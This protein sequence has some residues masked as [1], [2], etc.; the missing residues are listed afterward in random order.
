MAL[1]ALGLG[2]VFTARDLASPAMTRLGGRFGALD[3]V[4]TRFGQRFG[5]GMR[6]LRTAGLVFAA[7]G[8]LGTV[9]AFGLARA[10]GRFEEGLARVGGVT[11]ATVPE[12][13]ALRD[14]AIEVGIATTF[15]PDEAVEG[16]TSLAT[17]GF[18][19]SEAMRL[20]GP[21]SALAEGG[22]IGLEDAARAV[23]SATRVFSLSMDEAQGSADRLLRITQLTALQAGDLSLALGTVARGAGAT[24]QNLNEMLIAM[25]LVRNTGVEV[26]VAASGVSSAL[27]FMARQ[28]GEI[29][30]SLGVAITDVDGNFRDFLDIVLES[31]VALD[32]EFP[33]AADRASEALRLF[34]RF[35]SSAFGAVSRQLTQGIRGLNGELLT[36]ADAV[37][38]LRDQMQNATG[39]ADE[40]RERILA[41]FPGQLALL[42]GSVRTLA[43]V[44]G[45]NF[46]NA[47]KPIVRGVI[48]FV[49]DLITRWNAI[50]SAIRDGISSFLVG[51]TAMLTL[52][53]TFVAVS[54]GLALIAPL[55]KG[56]AIALG[57]LLLA[58]APLVLI[59]GAAVL[60]VQA[61]RFAMDFNLG[62]IATFVRGIVSRITLAWNALTEL[63]TRG[64]FTRAI[65]DELRRSE[66]QGLRRFV[67]GV[68]GIAFRLQRFWDGLMA[69]IRGGM[70]TLGPAIAAMIEAFRELADLFG[71]GAAKGED[72]ADALPTSAFVRFGQTLGRVLVRVARFFVEGLTT[73]LIFA[74]GVIKT[75]RSIGAR[76]SAFFAPLRPIL[77][78]IGLQIGMV[79][80]ALGQLS[81]QVQK[82]GSTWTEFVT[83]V[84]LLAVL[85]LPI[86]R[87]SLTG[88]LIMVVLL[89]QQFTALIGVF[90]RALDLARSI[91]QVLPSG[92]RE[93]G[94][95]AFGAA[96]RA[97]FGGGGAAGLAKEPVAAGV[98]RGGVGEALARPV[99]ESA[100]ARAARDESN[101]RVQQ[102][103]ID[104]LRA[105]Q[106]GIF[107][108]DMNLDGR[109]LQEFQGRME[110]TESAARGTPVEGDQ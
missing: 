67:L 88:I 80:S 83:V 90:T 26:S 42:S 40:F 29:Q 46:A 34:G 7:T 12:L 17:M 53:G 109:R 73:F 98:A 85:L 14:R 57:G 82:G 1:N 71:F 38:F 107:R 11:R 15:S 64:G 66:N 110:R 62:G 104:A 58:L 25:G 55:L 61:F 10:A 105:Q 78:E 60:G 108:I 31:S 6:R 95:A 49:N 70:I 79:F 5:A 28:A 72:M 101:V 44:L 3:R 23:A 21:A 65:S 43:I 2:F 18:Q 99:R 48:A 39:V 37:E 33:N 68:F 9:A 52:F 76:L 54:A 93:F 56:I 30:S 102:D 69:G 8:A 91:A 75:S 41:T 74:Q 59:F 20:I 35:G 103:I 92:Q 32:R 16:L 106:G 4:S 81:S 94:A 19:A 63:F 96:G 89:L 51:A 24:G 36:G 45:E 47:F 13:A 77:R 84:R 27:Q 97:V 50:P 22:M 86:M 100:E 87:Q